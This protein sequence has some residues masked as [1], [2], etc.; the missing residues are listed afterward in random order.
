METYQI[1]GVVI[2]IILLLGA[3]VVL[4]YFSPHSKDG[5]PVKPISP[6]SHNERQ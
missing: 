5:L 1:V 4:A 3:I 6:F 2:L